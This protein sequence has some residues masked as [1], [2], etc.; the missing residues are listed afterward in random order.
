MALPQAGAGPH[1]R[2][3]Q[4]LLNVGYQRWFGWD[5]G[6]DSLWSASLR[7]MLSE[8]EMASNVSGLARRLRETDYLIEA[9]L[10]VS[11]EVASLDDEQLVVTVAKVIAAYMRTIVSKETSFDRYLRVLLGNRA[12]TGD[13]SV[14]A[15]RGMKIFFGEGNCFVCHFGPNFSNGEFHDIGRPFF[16]GI[17]QVDAGRFSG[18]QRLRNDPFNLL[19]KYNGTNVEV[20]ILKTQTVKS[21][22]IN[23]GQWRTPS[24]RSLSLTAPYMHDGSLATLRDVVNYYAEIDPARLHG[25][26]EAILKPLHWSDSERESLVEFLKTLSE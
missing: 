15:Q 13:Y 24:L 6:A 3:T 7:P 1:V 8:S 11:I 18:I 2:N 4:G 25:K 17:G 16:T 12:D 5:G 9:L 21:G 10:Q 19:G 23:F 14:N 22:Q 26:G 20:D